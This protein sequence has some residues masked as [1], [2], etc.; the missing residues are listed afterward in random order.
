MNRWIKIGLNLLLFV[1]FISLIIYGQ[2]TIG[3]KYLAIQMIGLLG[4]LG[5]LYV[6]NKAYQ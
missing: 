5:Q 3:P 2:N 4:I 1:V 6:Y